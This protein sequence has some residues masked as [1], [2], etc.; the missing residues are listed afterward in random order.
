MSVSKW[1]PG[2][3]FPPR[4]T[5]IRDTGRATV[6]TGRR[7]R[8]VRSRGARNVCGIR[9]S[10]VSKWEPGSVFPLRRNARNTTVG[11][12]GRAIVGTGRRRTV[13][14]RSFV[15]R[16]DA[17]STTVRDTGRA[18]TGARRRR[19]TARSRGARNVCE[20]RR[21]SVSKWEPG[22]VFPLRRDVRST[23]VGNTGRAIV[24]TERRRT[25]HRGPSVLRRDTGKTTAGNN[26]R[27]TVGARRRRRTIRSRGA[28]NVCGIRR[29]SVSKW[30]PGSVFPLRRASTLATVRVEQICT[31]A[32]LRRRLTV[33]QHLVP[34]DGSF[35]VLVR[36]AHQDLDRTVHTGSVLGRTGR[37]YRSTRQGVLQLGV[38]T[39]D[40]TEV[41]DR[42]SRRAAL[43]T[44]PVPV[45]VHGHRTCMLGDLPQ[46]PGRLYR[47]TPERG[48]API[49]TPGQPRQR[50]ADQTRLGIMGKLGNRGTFG[51]DCVHSSIGIG[52]DGY[53]SISAVAR[54]R[55]PLESKPRS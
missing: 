52:D 33:A 55:R 49:E 20:I 12:T 53:S 31:V 38:G 44:P 15:L 14:R 26:G 23:T 37:A 27:A 36:D 43:A 35:T 17:G 22:S 40:R 32:A 28:R 11:N 1:E 16:R 48:V 50:H 13:H 45:P 34:R 6:G 51:T 7:R 2:S 25:V 54:G 3:V 24:G 41:S 9:R 18:T 30:E 42:A 29:L 39:V 5:T 19:R 47:G 21:L 10:S 8:T 46:L 4:C